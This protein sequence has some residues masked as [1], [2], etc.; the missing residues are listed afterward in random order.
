M[1]PDPLTLSPRDWN[2]VAIIGSAAHNLAQ[3]A[4]RAEHAA[5]ESRR[6]VAINLDE[7]QDQAKTASAA[8]ARLRRRH[9]DRAARRRERRS[10][11]EG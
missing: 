8:I 5:S 1:K 2:D 7:W 3:L 11:L 10:Q 6:P 4:S 9:Q